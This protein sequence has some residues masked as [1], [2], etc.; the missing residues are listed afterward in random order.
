MTSEITEDRFYMSYSRKDKN[1]FKIDVS[2]EEK[3]QILQALQENPKLK[4]KY[5]NLVKENDSLQK[6]WSKL[7]AEIEE[8]KSKTFISDTPVKVEFD[9]EYKKKYEQLQKR[10]EEHLSFLN[11]KEGRYFHETA[12]GEGE[13]CTVTDSVIELLQQILK[14]DEKC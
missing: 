5:D 10:I 3:Q 8:L 12:C 7:K 4:I 11:T 13:T 14:G 9:P 1:W 2:T 6:E